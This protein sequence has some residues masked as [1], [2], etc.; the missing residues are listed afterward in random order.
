MINKQNFTGS[1]VNEINSYLQELSKR[2]ELTAYFSQTYIVDNKIKIPANM[3]I[4]GGTFIAAAG[5]EDALFGA[6][7]DNIR[8]INATLAAPAHNKTPAIYAQH[9]KTTTAKISNVIGLF[10]NNHNNVGLINCVCDKIIPA[11][12]NNG[13]GIIENCVIK[14]T[15]MFIW[16]TNSK[17]HVS[18]NIVS[19]CNTG[20]DYYYHVYYLDKNSEL[21]S[22]NNQIR[23]NTSTPFFDIY[24]LMTAGNNGTY[25]ATGEINGDVIIGNF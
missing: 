23:C 24:H 8:I 11:K 5:Y 25:Y 21:Y 10:S 12:I 1:T 9:N 16:A 22:N 13:L 17:M 7:G 19:M 4:I 18:N 15:P 3:T 20:L 6:L 14:D 2:N